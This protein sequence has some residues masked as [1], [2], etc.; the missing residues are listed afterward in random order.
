MG[1]KTDFFR[2]GHKLEKQQYCIVGISTFFAKTLL[3]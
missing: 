2:L 1:D 3:V